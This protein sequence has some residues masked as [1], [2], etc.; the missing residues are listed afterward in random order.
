M[1]SWAGGAFHPA[2]FLKYIQSLASSYFGLALE[3][4]VGL[5]VVSEARIDDLA[6]RILAA[7][8]LLGQDQGYPAVNFNAFLPFLG[9]HVNVQDD[10]AS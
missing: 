1:Q 4:A 10:H 8:Y 7:W 9:Q 6:T 2:E 3:V 5:G